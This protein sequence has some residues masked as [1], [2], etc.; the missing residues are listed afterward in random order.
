MKMTLREY[1]LR[2]RQPFT[3]SHGTEEVQST[4]IVELE[5]DGLRGYGEAPDNTY[6]GVSTDDVRNR[7]EHCRA[8]IESTPWDRPED[9]WQAIH[10]HLEG[11]SFGLCAVDEAA[12]DLWGKRLGKPVHELWGLD[13]SKAP[14]SD[15]TIGIDPIPKMVEKLQ[16]FP[17]WPI[18][19][20]KLGTRDDVG[21]IRELRKHTDA[22][23]RVDANT[24]WTADETIHNSRLMKSLGV[25]FIEQPLKAGSWDEMRRVYQE[26]A[27]PIVADES[28]VTEGDVE[29]CVGYFHGVNIKLCKCG[30]LTP[31]LRMAKNAKRL[32][33]RL[34]IGCMP[35]TTVGISAIAQLLPLL[36][37]A[38][39]DGAVLLETDIADGVKV[40]RGQVRYPTVNGTGVTLL[41]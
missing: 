29:K 34:M 14:E 4:L 17:G 16:E 25:E 36:D 19:K 1:R 33:L 10:R 23:F 20:I 15:Y 31:G 11:C 2:L 3:T 13:P 18:Y 12:H 39:I 7:L 41:T 5:Q 8:L 35:E 30:G 9:L 22:I 40:E 21:I 28:C 32:G 26:S 38:D 37:Y 6:F 27:L 24:A